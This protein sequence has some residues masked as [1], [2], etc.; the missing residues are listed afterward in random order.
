VEL[1]NHKTSNL[2]RQ[3]LEISYFQI[4]FKSQKI[5]VLRE[6]YTEMKQSS[7]VV[8][9]QHGTVGSMAESAAWQRWLMTC[10]VE[11]GSCGS[12]LDMDYIFHLKSVYEQKKLTDS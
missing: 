2:S 12:N 11:L 7:L 5:N 10:S 4:I 9:W 1:S 3:G 6:G 8:G